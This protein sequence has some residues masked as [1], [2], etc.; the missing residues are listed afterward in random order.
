MNKKIKELTSSIETIEKYTTEKITFS[1]G[2]YTGKYLIDGEKNLW[3]SI[4]G[5][6]N[7]RVNCDTLFEVI[8]VEK[9]II[10]CFDVIDDDANVHF[11]SI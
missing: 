3:C 11:N 9:R 5:N 1:V 8:D 7:I 2:T 10:D 4:T 6:L